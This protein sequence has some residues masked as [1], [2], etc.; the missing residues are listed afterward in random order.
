MMAKYRADT[1]FVPV[2]YGL[3]LD[4]DVK[5]DHVA[6]WVACRSYCDFGKETGATISD[7]DAAIR[8]GMAERSF[9]RARS[10]LRKIGWLDWE[11]TGRGNT[12]IV[13]SAN[14]ADQK[15]TEPSPQIGQ[16]G[17]SD[18]PPRPNDITDNQTN[19]GDPNGSPGDGRTWITPFADLHLEVLGGKMQPK[20]WLR[21]FAEMKAD[22]GEAQVLEVQR[23]Y[24]ENLKGTG[25]Q[26]FLDYNKM[27]ESFGTWVAPQQ[28]PGRPTRRIDAGKDYDA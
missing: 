24:L 21:V 1:H 14:M 25:R 8:A 17:V 2:P 4:P 6:A 12:Y 22:H 19:N 27:A 10:E 9:R 15:Y 5:A 16:A 26:E 20:K 3:L 23:R 28:K 18:R 13:R 7:A 11:R